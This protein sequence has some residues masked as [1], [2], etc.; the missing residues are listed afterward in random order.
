MPAQ[1]LNLQYE[2]HLLV[3]HKKFGTGTIYQP[4]FGMELLKNNSDTSIEAQVAKDC[5]GKSHTEILFL[6]SPT[7]VQFTAGK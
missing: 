2:N 3:W 4:V 1:K 7:T 5:D 6:P